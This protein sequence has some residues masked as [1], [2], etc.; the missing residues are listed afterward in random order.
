MAVDGA[1]VVEDVRRRSVRWWRVGAVCREAAGVCRGRMVRRVSRMCVGEV[2]VGGGSGRAVGV[3]T[4][5]GASGVKTGRGASV[6]VAVVLDVWAFAGAGAAVGV[7]RAA[8]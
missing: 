2:S 8:A 6:G 1:G 5:R 4:G 7:G 3:K